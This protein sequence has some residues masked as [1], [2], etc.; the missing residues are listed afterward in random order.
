MR[1]ACSQLAAERN[2]GTGRS[3]AALPPTNLLKD[4]RQ[5]ASPDTSDGALTALTYRLQLEPSVMISSFLTSVR[6]SASKT[7]QSS[8]VRPGLA[9]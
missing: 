7:S 9:R 5:W 1:A 2:S 4:P 6:K 8:S 3:G